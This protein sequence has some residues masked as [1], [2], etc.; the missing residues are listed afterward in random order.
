ME[1]LIARLGADNVYR[2]DEHGTI[3]FITDG[4]LLWVR[5]DSQEAYNQT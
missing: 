5:T 3:E 4:E 1:R 2:T